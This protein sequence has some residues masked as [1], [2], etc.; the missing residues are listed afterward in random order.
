MSLTVNAKAYTAD[1]W[2]TNSVRFQG[3]AHTTSVKDR[4]IQKKT[5]PKPTDLFSG[6]SRFQVKAVRT[7]A[8]TGA[9]TATADGS[10]DVNFALPVGMPSADIDAYC[11]DLGA[12]LASAA[13]KAALKSGQ[14][15]G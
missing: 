10:M 6:I 15:N 12:Y 9:K 5:D 14:T 2:D 13:F 11:N 4:L 7:H 3:P 8:L 1:G